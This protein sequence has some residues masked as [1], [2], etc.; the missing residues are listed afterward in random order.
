MELAKAG[1]FMVE[2][3]IVLRD[4]TSCNLTFYIL[5]DSGLWSDKVIDKEIGTT[6]TNRL[7][8]S[9][10]PADLVCRQF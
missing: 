10:N 3:E 4:T 8:K 5:W 6:P 1:I 9:C 7:E 2:P